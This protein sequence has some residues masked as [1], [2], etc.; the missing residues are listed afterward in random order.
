[1]ASS[2]AFAG[3]CKTIQDKFNE[4]YGSVMQDRCV[5]LDL[6]TSL[7]NNPFIYTN[8][9]AGCDL[10]LQLPGLPDFGISSGG[11]NACSIAK[12]VTGP[13]V[14][15]VNSAMRDQVNQAVGAIDAA[16]VDAIGTQASGG[17][18]VGSLIEDQYEDLL[19]E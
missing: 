7:D 17:I 6:E 3:S 4:V 16:S 1:M 11:I 13:M 9:D 19:P 2:V 18:D 10:G 14:D 12:A 5:N 15:K 8:P